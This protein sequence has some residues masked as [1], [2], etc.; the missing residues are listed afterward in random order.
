MSEII[1]SLVAI[2]SPC[3]VV[4]LLLLVFLV[5]SLYVIYRLYRQLTVE[6]KRFFE[7]RENQECALKE[8]VNK[9]T[10]IISKQRDIIAKL[11]EES[12]KSSCPLKSRRANET[13]NPRGVE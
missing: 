9:L 6:Q 2:I 11:A 8:N 4:S 7:T 10:I 12:L 13:S 3:G 1:K 5:G